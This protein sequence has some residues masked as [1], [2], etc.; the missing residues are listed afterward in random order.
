MVQSKFIMKKPR[1]AAVFHSFISAPLPPHLAEAARD[2]TS[3]VCHNEQT[4]TARKLQ[5]AKVYTHIY[6]WSFGDC[7]T[8]AWANLRCSVSGLKTGR[9]KGRKWQ[10]CSAGSTEATRLR[11]ICCLRPNRAADKSVPNH[12][13]L[14]GIFNPP[15]MFRVKLTRLEVWAFGK[16]GS[17]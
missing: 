13:L 10:W 5:R 12:T 14:R 17:K 9:R 2:F 4:H 3:N 1:R 15:I 7:L 11:Q 16:N 8:V 6:N